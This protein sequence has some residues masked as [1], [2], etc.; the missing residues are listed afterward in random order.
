MQNV[1]NKAVFFLSK[2]ID[3]NNEKENDCLF[4]LKACL[5]PEDLNFFIESILAL[6]QVSY[7]K[8][9]NILLH[10]LMRLI[11]G[12]S[13]D[14]LVLLIRY[15]EK[16]E[17]KYFFM[18]N[19]TYFL[20]KRACQYGYKKLFELQTIAAFL[21]DTE[22]PNQE[23][24]LQVAQKLEQFFGFG[25]NCSTKAKSVFQ[26]LLN[27]FL[28][29]RRQVQGLYRW[30]TLM[31]KDWIENQAKNTGNRF[32]IAGL[33]SYGLLIT[34]KSYFLWQMALPKKDFLIDGNSFITDFKSITDFKISFLTKNTMS[35]IPVDLNYFAKKQLEYQKS[36]YPVSKFADFFYACD[37][38][39]KV[40]VDC[41]SQCKEK[42][43]IGS[44]ALSELEGILKYYVSI[45]KFFIQSTGQCLQAIGE[46][47]MIAIFFY[48]AYSVEKIIKKNAFADFAMAF[49]LFEKELYNKFTI[50][51][52]ESKKI[53]Y[54]ELLLM[55]EGKK[56]LSSQGLCGLHHDI[57]QL[58]KL[59][60]LDLIKFYLKKMKQN[61]Q[62]S[63]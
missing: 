9:K 16:S 24:L 18:G 2:A 8:L 19:D 15:H 54:L 10:S 21:D 59:K 55:Y 28:H 48:C 46:L 25:V 11:I 13:T 36:Y 35:D 63:M 40:G 6:D 12:Y 41:F 38:L 31:V 3:Q 37:V 14:L 56:V 61:Y 50:D 43:L 7:L 32:F 1:G 26:D 20:A 30:D 57:M 51:L 27:A 22:S 47:G 33:M 23:T 39:L 4:E 42:V 29:Y 60:S 34:V 5:H 49:E 44:K 45:A 58:K 52:H 17:K 53:V 62:L